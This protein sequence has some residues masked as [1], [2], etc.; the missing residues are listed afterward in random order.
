MYNLV[1][2]R[3]ATSVLGF[4]F[5]FFNPRA[6]MWAC[7]LISRTHVEYYNE[8]MEMCSLDIKGGLV[9]SKE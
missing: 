8:G 7:E 1:L 3:V 6:I 2:L 5:G 4:C 9:K